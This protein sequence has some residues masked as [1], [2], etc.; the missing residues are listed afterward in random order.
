MYRKTQI[1]LNGYPNIF[2]KKIFDKIA[3]QKHPMANMPFYKQDLNSIKIFEEVL[4]ENRI[5]D[6]VNT[7]SNSTGINISDI[8]ISTSLLLAS[9]NQIMAAK[10]EK[11]II[12]QLKILAEKIVREQYN[13]ECDEITFDLEIN[14]SEPIILPDEVN[15]EKRVSSE[16]R[17]TD[18]LDII[19]K[20]TINALGQGAALKSHYIF[21]LYRDEL[22]SLSNNITDYYQK[23][24]IANDLTYFIVDDDVFLDSLGGGDNNYTGGYYELNFDGDVPKI[25]AKAIN[26]PLLIHEMVKGV[27][28]FFSIQGIQNMSNEIIDETDYVGAE[29]WDIRFGPTIWIN[30]HSLID[31]D[32]DDI[33]KLI[34]V[35]IFNKD[36]K[37]FVEFMTDVMNY[38]DIAKKEIDSIAQGI[39]RKIFN[40]NYHSFN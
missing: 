9:Q 25:I 32:Y 12:E 17:Q 8:R 34:F 22:N 28:A 2:N 23:L 30:L 37:S 38:P 27:I 35:E 11:P 29:L 6:L 24:L 13:L 18:D 40:Y 7:F 4:I 5:K 14:M 10:L 33:K 16:F 3:E 26:F 36:S 19:K 21:H 39:R 15:V 31:I 1:D 20:R